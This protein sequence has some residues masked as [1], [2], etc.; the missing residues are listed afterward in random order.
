[1]SPSPM[2]RR[3]TDSLLFEV[4]DARIMRDGASKYVVSGSGNMWRSVRRR[5]FNIISRDADWVRVG[6]EG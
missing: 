3:A 1:M 6:L 4:T 2:G 5:H